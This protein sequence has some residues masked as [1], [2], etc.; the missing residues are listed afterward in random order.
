MIPSCQSPDGLFTKSLVNWIRPDGSGYSAVLQAQSI[1]F[2]VIGRGA[3]SAETFQQSTGVSVVSGGLDSAL[4]ELPLPESAIVAVGVEQLAPVAQRLIDAGCRRLLLE[5]PG[6]LH[7][8]ELEDLHATADANDAKVWIA[9]NRRFYRS[10]QKLRQLAEA[11][12]GFTSAVFEFTEWSPTALKPPVM[13]HWLL[14][15]PPMLLMLSFH[16]P[17]L[18]VWQP[19][20]AEASAGILP[21]PASMVLE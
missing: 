13:E 6:A 1:D 19:G 15:A 7:L 14:A 12:G 16:W 8:T 4:A 3:A 17:A 20:I 5:K 2:R 18:R 11:D 21:L 10:V 9:Y